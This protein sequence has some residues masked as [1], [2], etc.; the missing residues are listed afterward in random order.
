MIETL[1]ENGADVNAADHEGKQ[2]SEILHS[3]LFTHS[4]V[5]PGRTALHIASSKGDSEAV[6][7]LIKKGRPMVNVYDQMGNTP[8]NCALYGLH[9][10]TASLLLENNSR[11]D[12]YDEQGKG[13]RLTLSIFCQP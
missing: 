12:I 4:F 5:R 7:L 6:L 1:L 10:D 13:L 8:L 11:I 9:E 3:V 2:T